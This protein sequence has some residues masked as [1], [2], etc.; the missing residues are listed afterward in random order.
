M[1]VDRDEAEMQDAEPAEKPTFKKLKQTK[2]DVSGVG[3][4]I[5]L[6]ACLCRALHLSAKAHAAL[7]AVNVSYIQL[8]EICTSVCAFN[9]QICIECNPPGTSDCQQKMC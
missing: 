4:V 5:S 2:E 6:T 1:Q 9:A 7:A 8:Y 3:K